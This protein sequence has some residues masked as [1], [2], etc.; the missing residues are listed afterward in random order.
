M[1]NMGVKI[2]FPLNS[3]FYFEQAMEELMDENFKQ[4]IEYF[5]KV[6]ENDKSLEVN[7]LYS[8]ALFTSERVDKA[9]EIANDLKDTYIS[10]EEMSVFYAMLLI[11]SCSS[12]M[13]LAQVYTAS[14]TKEMPRILA[15]TI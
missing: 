5:K 3:K 12:H 2:E 13:Y 11:M 14:Y 8:A 15:W 10:N 9:L 6:Y 4:A 7:R 1:N